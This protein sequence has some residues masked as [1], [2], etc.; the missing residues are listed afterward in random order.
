MLLLTALVPFAVGSL[1]LVARCRRRGTRLAGGWRAYRRRLGFWLLGLVAL[2]LVALTG[3]L[4]VA[5]ELPPRP[6]LPPLDRWPVAGIG[7][8]A[9]AGL[10]A[11]LRERALLVPRGQTDPEEELGGWAVAFLALL[12]VAVLVALV[13]P[14]TLLFVVPSL[15]A[16]LGA[17]QVG[18]NRRWLADGLFGLGLLGPLVAVVVVGRQLSLGLEAPLYAVAL[19]TS[20]TVPWPVSVALAAWT[21]A[22]AQ[23]AALVAGRYA[24]LE[25]RPRRR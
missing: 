23:I 1:D 12:G 16:W 6:D 14:Y 5:T 7:V 22:A 17:V 24:P 3:A 8:L 13:S 19:L 25:D 15:Y 18:R 21:A 4:P 20:G 9:L 10:L 2:G 11:W